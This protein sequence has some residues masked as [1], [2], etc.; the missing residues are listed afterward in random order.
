M[1]T[2]GVGPW[3]EGN[4]YRFWSS[5]PAVLS[6]PVFCLLISSPF[7]NPN[8]NLPCLSLLGLYFSNWALF[9]SP[10]NWE[11]PSGKN[12]GSC[13]N[14]FM[15]F[16]I[17]RDHSPSRSLKPSNNCFTYFIQLLWLFFAWGLVPKKALCHRQY[18][19]VLFDFWVFAL[20]VGETQCR[21]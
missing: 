8:S 16:P 19:E 4:L 13:G 14:Y 5:F 20:L 17:L 1:H 12:L 10:A 11:T 6:S 18:L 9:S 3:L 15:S 7:G 2:W 21:P